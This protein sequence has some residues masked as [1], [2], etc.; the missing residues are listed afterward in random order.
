[1]KRFFW[2]SMLLMLLLPA[3]SPGSS[4]AEC[5]EGICVRIEVAGPVQA[6]APAP[7]V[8]AIKT[9][10]DISNLGI[11]LYD[12][13]SI[14]ILD[15]EKQPASA[16][17]AYQDNRSAD[18]WIDTKGGEEYIISGHVILDQPTVSYGYFR[19]GLI[20]AA[21]HPSIARV[22]DSVT[23]YLDAEGKQIEESRAKRM[24][25]TD[26]P[27][28]TPPPDLIVITDTPSPTIVWPTNTSSFYIS[29]R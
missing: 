10:K 27:L 25:E 22:T 2:L 1:M 11:S 29:D 18:W 28:P 15:I 26:F 21:A 19:Y 6:L 20:A 7:F 23:I 14:T 13:R 12:G 8:M 9:D 3:C 16:K 4:G 5:K 17:L 24:S